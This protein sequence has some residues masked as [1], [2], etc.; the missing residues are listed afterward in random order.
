MNKDRKQ[1]APLTRMTVVL[2]C[3]S[4]VG[5]LFLADILSVF[6]Q[7]NEEKS[8]ILS[9]PQGNWASRAARSHVQCV[10]VCVLSGKPS[11]YETPSGLGWAP[12]SA[13]PLCN[14]L[15]LSLPT[16]LFFLAHSGSFVSLITVF[17]LLLSFPLL[18]LS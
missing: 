15:Y 14:R 11:G 6:C 1:W 4:G 5:H 3:K 12:A 13:L 10:Y 9:S 18:L 17:L 16:S 7:K 8:I 2:Y